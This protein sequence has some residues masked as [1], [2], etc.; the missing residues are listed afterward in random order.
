MINKEMKAADIVQLWPQTAAVFKR[1]GIAR[2]NRQKLSQLFKAEK[3]YL[4]VIA[5]NDEIKKTGVGKF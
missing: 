5:L 2:D 4:L 1:Y 3:L